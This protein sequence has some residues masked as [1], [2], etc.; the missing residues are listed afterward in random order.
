M[1]GEKPINLIDL[2]LA[3]APK[4]ET[5]TMPRTMT[6]SELRAIVEAIREQR[7]AAANGECIK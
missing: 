6:L 2:Q 3:L 1:I 4:V 7:E 5:F